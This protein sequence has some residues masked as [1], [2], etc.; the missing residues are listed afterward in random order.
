MNIILL[1]IYNPK[2][3]KITFLPSFSRCHLKNKILICTSGNDCMYSYIK[4]LSTL[5]ISQATDLLAQIQRLAPEL[6]RRLVS[7]D[8][9]LEACPFTFIVSLDLI[10]KQKTKNKKGNKHFQNVLSKKQKPSLIKSYL[11]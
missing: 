5:C 3:L 4:L 2:I 7:P 6:R 10:Q 8:V 11:P 1:H 9:Y